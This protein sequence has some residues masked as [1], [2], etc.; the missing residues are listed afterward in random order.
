LGIGLGLGLCLCLLAE[1]ALAQLPRESPRYGPPYRRGLSFEVAPGLALC[2]PAL[3]GGGVCG[4]RGGAPAQPG[5][6]LR[7]SLGWRFNDFVLVSAGWVRQ[8]HLPGGAFVGGRA[9]GG[10]AALRGILPLPTRRGDDSHVDL[11]LE[12][13]LGYSQRV[14]SRDAAPNRLSSV[15]ALIRPALVLEGWVIA[16]L[17]LG[18]EIATHLNL[19]WQHCADASCQ[20]RPGDWVGGGLER[21]WVD[22]LTVAVRATGLLF[23]NF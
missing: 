23:P 22:G 7:L 9:D 5:L 16:D 12:L 4:P 13:G 15:G 10:M 18:L 2:Q 19:H 17:A 1:P 14:L 21:R 20:A 3:L 6:A 8:S 11:G